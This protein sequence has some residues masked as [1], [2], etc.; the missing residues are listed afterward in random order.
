MLIIDRYRS[1]QRTFRGR[2]EAR[3]NLFRL[4]CRDSQVEA[5]CGWPCY[6]WFGITRCQLV[7]LEEGAA[8]PQGDTIVAP[9]KASFPQSSHSTGIPS[10]L[11]VPPT[12]PL[13][14]CHSLVFQQWTNTEIV[15]G[16]CTGHSENSALRIAMAT[17]IKVDPTA[18]NDGSHNLPRELKPVGPEGPFPSFQRSLYNGWL[19]VATMGVSH[20]LQ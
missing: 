1:S 2:N 12:P 15:P 5:G 9:P 6:S 13:L 3:K 19:P 16:H 14:Y 4:G 10:S 8:K 17:S 7:F 20:T 11:L 18:L